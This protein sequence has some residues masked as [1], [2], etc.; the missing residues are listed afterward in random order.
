ML[1]IFPKG[2]DTFFRTSIDSNVAELSMGPPKQAKLTGEWQQL[3]NRALQ[4]WP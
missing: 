3:G 4:V 1:S 2:E